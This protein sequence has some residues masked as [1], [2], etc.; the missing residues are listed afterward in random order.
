MAPR[1]SA[2]KKLYHLV[3]WLAGCSKLTRPPGSIQHIK[4][5]QTHTSRRQQS[6]VVEMASRITTYLP[7]RTTPTDIFEHMSLLDSPLRPSP[8]EEANMLK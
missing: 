5:T 8:T 3:G 4:P 1:L 2:I 6:K 7:S